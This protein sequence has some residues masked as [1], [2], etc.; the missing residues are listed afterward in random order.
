[1]SSA[2]A[3]QRSIISYIRQ[4]C[5]DIAGQEGAGSPQGDRRPF[6][7]RAILHLQIVYLNY[8]YIH[9]RIG[10]CKKLW[11]REGMRWLDDF[12]GH[13]KAV[14]GEE[15]TRRH[16]TLLL[17]FAVLVYFV[18]NGAM[19]ITDP[20]ESNYV[21]TAKEMMA[22]GDLFSP[23]IYGRYWYDKPG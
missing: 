20:V 4:T 6:C 14:S 23:R 19:A 9:V 13:R 2:L 18:G 17:L 8:L 22:S 21:E 11:G 16:L 5:S 7:V 12:R 15:T 10:V 1:M 3:A